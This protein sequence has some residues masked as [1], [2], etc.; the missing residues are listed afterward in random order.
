MMSGADPLAVIQD[1]LEIDPFP[2][3]RESRA[4]RTGLSSMVAQSEAKRAGSAGGANCRWP[5]LTRAWQM[6]LK[7]LFEVRDS[8]PPHPGLPKWR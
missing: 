1:L 3:P 7:G 8:H 2:H 6:L 4:H 5:S